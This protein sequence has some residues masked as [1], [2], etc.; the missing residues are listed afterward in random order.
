MSV[1]RGP[2]S[3]GAGR[4][5]ATVK[6]MQTATIVT[7]PPDREHRP[8]G[9]R[10]LDVH[11]L[12]RRRRGV[13]LA[14]TV[15]W[16]GDP[17]RHAGEHRQRLILLGG[18]TECPVC[19]RELIVGHVVA[20]GSAIE[21]LQVRQRFCGRAER[22]SAC[23][24]V[25]PAPAR[26]PGSASGLLEEHARLVELRRFSIQLADL[27]GRVRIGRD[28]WPSSCFELA[29]GLGCPPGGGLALRVVRAATRPMRKWMPGRPGALERTSGTP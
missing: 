3:R 15:V 19:L 9:W 25:R 16:P 26:T 17:S 23:A 10:G 21:A 5:S 22:A 1:K 29:H 4:S 2:G 6:P 28:R 27:I 14:G 8:H 11:L 7:T 18:I 12:L 20:Q 24:R 13:R